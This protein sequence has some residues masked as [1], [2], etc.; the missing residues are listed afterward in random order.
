MWRATPTLA[1]C[2]DYPTK[3]PS[4][5]S[6]PPNLASRGRGR[7]T[8][9]EVVALAGTQ[10]RVTLRHV[11]HHAHVSV[12][13]AS[14]SLRNKPGVSP[15]TRARVKAV[16][17]ALG[18]RADA[19]GVLLRGE[20]RPIVGI[21][22]DINESAPLNHQCLLANLVIEL[23]SASCLVSVLSLGDATPPLDL[24]IIL[25]G[26]ASHL[27]PRGLGFGTPV[28]RAAVSG[29]FGT[30]SARDRSRS[31][32]ADALHMLAQRQS[33]TTTSAPTGPVSDPPEFA[34][35]S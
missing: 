27:P 18:Y 14:L 19:T 26:Q 24:L 32:A 15:A 21:L 29:L 28:I 35:S 7:G 1:S 11:A 13:T 31:I 17:A 5:P 16:A 9:A 12:A 8:R 2:R 3:P 30:E 22:L 33:P 23:G 6:T 25:D 34:A 4:L 20:R 10:P